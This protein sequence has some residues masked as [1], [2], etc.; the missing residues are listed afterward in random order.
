LRIDDLDVACLALAF[1]APGSYTGEDA[2]EL[3]LPGNPVLLARVTDALIASGRGRGLDARRAEAGEFTARAYL[4]G[5]LSLTQ[6][7]GVAAVIA[8][9]SDAQLRAGRLLA[10][11]ISP[12]RRTWSPSHHASCSGCCCGCAIGS[13][14]G[15]TGRW[16]ANSSR[17]C[18]GSS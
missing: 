1:P 14:P 15:S 5:K 17:R 13:K 6:A 12:T 4:N 11:S 18:R 8:A 7:E 10:G 3:Q 9:R 2:A 16:A